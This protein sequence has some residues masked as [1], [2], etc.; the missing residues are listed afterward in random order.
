MAAAT[1]TSP[2]WERYA[3][4]AGILYVLA[5]VAE[6]AVG[7][8]VGINQNDSAAVVVD[9]GHVVVDLGMLSDSERGSLEAEVDTSA[10]PT[11]TTTQPPAPLAG[12]RLHATGMILTA[13]ALIVVGALLLMGSRRL[14]DRGTK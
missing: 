8:G 9:P 7:L 11:T 4:V 6:S 10:P 13:L 5:V 12:T 3:W 1:R 2:T 14:S